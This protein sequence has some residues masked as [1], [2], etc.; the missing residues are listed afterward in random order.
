[1]Q[2]WVGGMGRGGEAYTS[3]L[4]GEAVDIVGWGGGTTRA[5]FDGGCSLG[6]HFGCMVGNT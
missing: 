1:M 2:C 6:V 3:V 4:G 5:S